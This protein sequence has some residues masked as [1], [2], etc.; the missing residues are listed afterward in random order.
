M[1]EMVECMCTYITDRLDIYI[2]MLAGE[3]S[4]KVVAETLKKY[5]IEKT[6]IDPVCRPR[7]IDIG[8]AVQ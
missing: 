1:I 4:I 8:S 3:E 6:V 2:G 7:Y 5:S